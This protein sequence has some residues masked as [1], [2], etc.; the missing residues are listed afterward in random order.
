MK[1]QNKRY[2]DC[3]ICDG[4]GY[5]KDKSYIVPCPLCVLKMKVYDLRK[6][7]KSINFRIARVREHYVVTDCFKNCMEEM[8]T[9]CIDNVLILTLFNRKRLK[10][11]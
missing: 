1:S 7:E 11:L 3:Y 5:V 8:C 9:D 6:N 2:K 10:D 4:L